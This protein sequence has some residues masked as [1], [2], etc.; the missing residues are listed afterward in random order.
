MAIDRRAFPCVKDDKVVVEILE[1]VQNSAGLKLLRIGANEAAKMLHKGKAEFI[2]IAAD[3]LP[4]E[5]VLHLPLLCEDKD[6]PYVYVPSQQTLG[7][8][9]GISRPVTAVA[10]VKSDKAVLAKSLRRLRELVDSIAQ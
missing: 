2:I 1:I 9:A 4:L 8:S 7:R 5:I 10:I 6:V 3:T